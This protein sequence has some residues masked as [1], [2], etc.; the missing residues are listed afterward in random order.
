MEWEID[1]FNATVQ[2]GILNFP[3][4]LQA[5]YIHLADRMLAFGPDLGMPHTRAM[6][7]GLFELRLKSKEGNARI[8]FCIRPV[9]RILMLHS[10]FK[11]SAKTPGKEL[12]IARKRLK[13]IMDNDV[14]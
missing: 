14:S 7:N 5:R 13:E 12:K 9:R 6:G 8:F 11:K 10:F 1:Y 3:V 4:K 2:D